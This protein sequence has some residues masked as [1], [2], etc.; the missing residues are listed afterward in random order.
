MSALVNLGYSQGDAAQAIMMAL[1]TTDS[2]TDTD[3]KT[4]QDLIKL[5]LKILSSKN[6]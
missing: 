1:D 3:I 5:T 6:D 4:A 2:T